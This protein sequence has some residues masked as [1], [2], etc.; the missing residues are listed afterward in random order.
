MIS[1]T[2]VSP[3]RRN[4]G[5]SIDGQRSKRSLDRNGG[6]VKDDLISNFE[7]DEDKLISSIQQKRQGKAK[8]VEGVRDRQTKIM[9]LNEKIRKFDLKKVKEDEYDGL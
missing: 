1:N 7:T 4:R 6:Y 9:Q 2:S 3:S 8:F 5:V